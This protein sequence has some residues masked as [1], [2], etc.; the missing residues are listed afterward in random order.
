MSSKK[1]LS[2]SARKTTLGKCISLVSTN[3]QIAFCIFYSQLTC[4]L[5]D[6]TLIIYF[7]C[8][9]EYLSL[10]FYNGGLKRS[11]VRVAIA[12]EGKRDIEEPTAKKIKKSISADTQTDQ[13]LATLYQT[14]F[15][16]PTQIETGTILTL[17]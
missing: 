7:H 9:Q 15:L 3:S 2:L 10:V 14:D 4:S 12:Q 5:A 13:S 8:C 17:L 1:P 16:S 11:L 6:I